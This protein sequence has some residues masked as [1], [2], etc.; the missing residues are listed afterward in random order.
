[1]QA[2]RLWTAADG[3]P[4][5]FQKFVAENTA[6]GADRDLIFERFEAKL[7]ALRGHFGA[8]SLELRREQDEDR[9]ELKPVDRLFA[10]FAPDAH[11]VDDLF[12]SR[13]GFVAALNFPLPTLEEARADGA[14]WDRRR[15]AE[16][17]LA[18]AFAFRVP[19][20][21]RQKVAE[22]Q[23]AARSYI[24]GYD[25]HM[26]HVVGS[27]G[28]PLFRDGL[29]L[30]S[31][32]GLRD[33][34]R[35]LY[36]DPQGLPQQKLILT[37]MERIIRQE[38][39]KAAV[40]GREHL[41]D[42]ARNTL[43]GRPAEREPDTRYETLLSLFRAARLEDPHYPGY[44]TLMDRSFRLEREM[45]EADVES[46][47]KS[48]LEAPASRATARLVE[49]RLGR[50]LLPFDI[51][52]EGFKP[53]K[54]LPLDQLDAFVREKYP[55]ADAFRQSIPDILEK[56]G[57]SPET[58][59]FLAMHIE[60]DAARGAGHA[61]GPEMRSDMSHLRTRVGK[62][63]MD[64]QSFNIAMHELGHCVEQT[65]SM[66]KIDHYLLNGVPNTAFTEGF[67]FVFQARDLEVLGLKRPDERS[68]ALKDLD[69]FWSARQ[70]AGVALV[71]IRT[72]HWMYGHPQATAAELREAMTRIAED[73][74][75]KHYAPIFGMK[76]SP[77]LAVYSHMFYHMLYTPNYP[78]GRLIA[79]QVEDYF[80]THALG[81][82]MERM[83]RIGSVTPAEWMR[84]AVGGPVSAQPM[85]KAAEKALASL[86]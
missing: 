54:S 33:H 55:T 85:I 3:S 46:L 62:D 66:Q 18:K 17:R 69:D 80:K 53:P 65:F 23:A 42:P 44:P 48:L 14:S 30:I 72:W 19:A 26:D 74:W 38:V 83:C 9:G 73:V 32:W 15:W 28:K 2:R 67:A 77:I 81:T 21:V 12:K 5:D 22:S 52:Y 59:A 4:E 78:L 1:L 8:M 45:P 71:D 49:R 31:H 61:L 35:A 20:E 27:D 76:D 58:A 41:W 11:L 82:E 86:R 64:Y 29:K 51:W 36:A 37:I 39:P 50:R 63:G 75:N 56:L 68:A 34:L 13:L 10:A 43:D 60:V 40:G 7:E 24:Y 25:I 6:Q 47:L 16:A 70:M 79:F 57:F 84:Q